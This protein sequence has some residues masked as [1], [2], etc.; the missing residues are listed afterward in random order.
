M[1][2]CLLVCF[3]CS[4][5]ALNSTVPTTDLASMC[6]LVH[7]SDEMLHPL[8]W[9]HYHYQSHLCFILTSSPIPSMS[10]ILSFS[11]LQLHVTASAQPLSFL[12][13]PLTCSSVSVLSVLTR[14]SNWWRNG[15]LKHSP[16][17]VT[18]IFSKMKNLTPSLRSTSFLQSM[19]SMTDC[20]IPAAIYLFTLPLSHKLV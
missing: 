17:C 12:S 7:F 5:S 11:S 2:V 3:F 14:L 16:D 6:Y 15:F 10:E 1:F 13:W 4:S 19:A 8:I 18:P 20:L 9:S